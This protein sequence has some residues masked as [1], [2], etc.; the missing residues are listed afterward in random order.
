VKLLSAQSDVLRT[1]SSLG[2]CL[3]LPP[4]DFLQTTLRSSLPS[5]LVFKDTIPNASSSSNTVHKP[6]HTVQGELGRKAPEGSYFHTKHCRAQVHLLKYSVKPWESK[7]RN[8]GHR[9]PGNRDC[10]GSLEETI[11]PHGQQIANINKN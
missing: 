2:L 11:T 4:Q 3:Y 6:W 1:C 9:T 10:M 5:K 7:H 8:K